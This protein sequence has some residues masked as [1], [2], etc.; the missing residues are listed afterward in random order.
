VT[1]P[2]AVPAPSKLREQAEWMELLSAVAV[3]VL[4]LNLVVHAF[5]PIT[6]VVSVRDPAAM[7]ALAQV[8][9]VR[10]IQATPA[11]LYLCGLWAAHRMFARMGRGEVFTAA[12]AAGLASIG[13]SLL[14]GSAWALALAPTLLR[15]TE[16]GFNGLDLRLEGPELVIL[17]LGG[18]L[19][20]LGKVMAQAVVLQAEVDAFV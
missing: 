20:M 4:A 3:G 2:A 10:A 8:L 18:A 17:V 15:W 1:E 12:N 16:D 6:T 9:G 11:I 13:A 19:M 5:P 14:W 7:W